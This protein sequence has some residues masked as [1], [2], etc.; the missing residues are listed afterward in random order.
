MKTFYNLQQRVNMSL[1]KKKKYFPSI[2][3][4]SESFI[5]LSW[6]EKP[7]TYYSVCQDY[8]STL[9]ILK[10]VSCLKTNITLKFKRIRSNKI[11]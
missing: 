5:N 6:R 3:L 1:V 11:Y 7:I 9:S 10:N 8:F 4:F 2:S